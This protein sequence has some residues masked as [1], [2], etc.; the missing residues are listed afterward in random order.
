MV[1][2]GVLLP[3]VVTSTGD[4]AN[5]TDNDLA[6]SK[7][8]LVLG[9]RP[10]ELDWRPDFG[11]G[12]HLLRHQNNTDVLAAMAGVYIRQAFANWL[13][14]LMLTTIKPT[15]DGRSLRFAVGFNIRSATGA[16]LLPRDLT[17]QIAVPLAAASVISS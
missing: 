3:F 9:T 5:G 17:A 13:P 6:I 14:S 16:P 1:L 2:Q 15:L 10:G 4:V 12:I 7:V 11:C 8:T